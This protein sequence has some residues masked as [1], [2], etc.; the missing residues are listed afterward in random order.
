MIWECECFVLLIIEFTAPSG[1]LL[2][3]FELLLKDQEELPMLPP[4]R[5]DLYM[6]PFGV[7]PLLQRTR[8]EVS[9]MKPKSLVVAIAFS[10]III[11]TTTTIPDP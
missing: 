2:A 1:E 5:G 6:V 11:S 4:T 3:A 7:R 8:I 9:I 10:F